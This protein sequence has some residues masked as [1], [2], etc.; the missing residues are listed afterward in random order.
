MMMLIFLLQKFG[1]STVCSFTYQ[2][3][4]HFCYLVLVFNNIF[5]H[6][7]EFFLASH[8]CLAVQGDQVHLICFLSPIRLNQDCQLLQQGRLVTIVFCIELIYTYFSNIKMSRVFATDTRN[9]SQK[10]H[11]V[12]RKNYSHV[13]TQ[14]RS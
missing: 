2:I 9:Q 3:F 6:Y 5:C 10:V 11:K 8:H 12:S 13:T 14:S 1:A 7:P 4:C